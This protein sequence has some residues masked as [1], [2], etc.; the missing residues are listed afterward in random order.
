MA[1]R[2]E[3]KQ[4]LWEASAKDEAA[5][6]FLVEFMASKSQDGPGGYVSDEDVAEGVKAIAPKPQK[7]VKR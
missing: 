5:R 1:N 2:S 4:A 6:A 7:K 3:A